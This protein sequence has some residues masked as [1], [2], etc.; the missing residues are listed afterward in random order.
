MAVER[1]SESLV[2]QYPSNV[3]QIKSDLSQIKADFSQIKSDLGQLKDSDLEDRLH[4]QLRLLVSNTLDL[5]PSRIVRSWLQHEPDADF[6]RCVEDA[7]ARGR[8]TFDQEAS[9][10]FAD[11]IMRARRSDKTMVWVA[12]E[13]SNRVRACDIE[14]ARVT[15]D[16]LQAV[17]NVD[18]VAAVAG[19]S[20][21][22]QDA[23]RAK[24]T[25][26]HYLKAPPPVYWT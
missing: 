22:A 8:I 4:R 26:V 12:V 6:A 21:Y 14:R 5:R 11:F 9:I 3:S 18:A 24:S 19:Y 16:A 25:Q 7:V 13:A 10:D 2:A 20:I 17:F 23:E 15:A 1:H